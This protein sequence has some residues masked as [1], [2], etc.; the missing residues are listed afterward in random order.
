MTEPVAAVV[1]GVDVDAVAAAA[2]ACAHVR[3]L[4]AKSDADQVSTY[5]PGRVID[6]VR[7]ED[8]AVVL[9]VEIAWDASAA[10]VADELATAVAGLIGDRRVDVVIAS[11]AD[12]GQPADLPELPAA[13]TPA[14]PTISTPPNRPTPPAS[15]TP[16]S[17]P[18]R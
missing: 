17:T 15:P 5:T 3:T 8:D 1:D 13:S 9:S 7:V 4:V 10:Q 14:Q 11:V 6:G 16:P 2:V 18:D 12:P